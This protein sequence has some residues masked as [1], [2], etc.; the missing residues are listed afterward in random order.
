MFRCFLVRKAEELA[1]K[2]YAVR[3][4]NDSHVGSRN[5]DRAP[6]A[7]PIDFMRYG[8]YALIA[9]GIITWLVLMW[10]DLQRDPKRKEPEHPV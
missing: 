8:L 5:G 7:P 4:R 10:R 2:N 3:T 9:I 6:A 1:D